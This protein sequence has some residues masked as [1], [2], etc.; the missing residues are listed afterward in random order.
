MHGD[1]CK[2][3]G[4]DS[5]TDHS[6][7]DSKG[8]SRISGKG[9]MR[10]NLFVCVRACVCVCVCV[11]ACVRACVCVCGRFFADFIYFFLKYPMKMK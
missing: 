1:L 7:E 10:Q 2:H 4:I 6:I 5:S 9:F 3:L 8:G 11:C